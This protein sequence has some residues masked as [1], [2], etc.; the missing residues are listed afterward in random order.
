M[1]YSH[2][3]AQCRAAGNGAV[4]SIS[5]SAVCACIGLSTAKFPGAVFLIRTKYGPSDD[6]WG[7][8]FYHQI[9]LIASF[10][11]DESQV[12]FSAQTWIAALLRTLAALCL[13]G[14]D[15]EMIDVG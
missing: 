12:Q 13:L 10:V 14:H 8:G 4:M 6:T 9:E 1:G 7:H 11:R 2:L 3:R 5:A 15:A